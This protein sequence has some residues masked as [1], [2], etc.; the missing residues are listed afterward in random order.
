MHRN[1]SS[2]IAACLF[3]V[4][5]LQAPAAWAQQDED[6]I[7]LDPLIV[8][9]TRSA[10]RLSQTTRSVTVISAEDIAAQG[11]HT[12]A[13]ALRS[14]LGLDVVR[15][16]SLGATTSIFTRGSESDHTAVLID[17][18]KVNILLDGKFDMADLS[19][20]N[21]ER[22]EVVRGPA[23][24]LYGST[25]TGGVIHIITK[26]GSGPL[27]ANL[28]VS[29]GSFGTN[30]QRAI[31][32]GGTTWGGLSVS[33]SRVD[34]EGHLAF[35]NQYDNANVALRADLSPDERTNVDLTL[36]YIDSEYHFPTDGAGRVLFRNKYQTTHETTLGLRG[37]RAL[38]PWWNNSLQ[39]GFHQRRRHSYPESPEESLFVTSEKRLA[40]DW[41]SVLDFRL[42]ALTLGAA[43][44]DDEDTE[45]DFRR[46]TTAGYAQLRLKPVEPI[47]LVGGLRVDEHSKFGTELTYQV[48]AAYFLPGGTKLR[49][50]LG[51]GFKAP[52]LF[53]NLST[54]PGA[55]G[56]PNLDPERST[57]WELGVEHKLWA[58]R[59]RFEGT[60][61][62]SRFKDLIDWGPA[63]QG[64]PNYFNIQE[65]E[66]HGLELSA[67][68][69]PLPAWT[70]GAA[71]TWLR[72]EVTDAGFSTSATAAFVEGESLLRRP[73]HKVHAFGSY[74]QGR[75]NG[76][77]DLHHIGVRN[78]RH[79]PG[80]PQPTRAVDNPS[81]TKVNV[82]LGYKLIAGE[83][84]T[85]ELFG[86]VENL[87]DEDYYEVY[88]FATPGF[89]AFGGI[90]MTL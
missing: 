87:F 31:V 33:A 89:A 54:L 24:T 79:Y 34:S 77:L 58:D 86:R 68:V 57:T 9:A 73:E 27:S 4:L 19:V 36:R 74:A 59:L 11:A 16:G 38:L 75:F 80:W 56:N 85:L 90:R 35:N 65:A 78:D 72:S 70:F 18:V 46:Y 64:Q 32:S 55:L 53:E 88:G 30:T 6:A 69:T 60:F 40:I 17:G 7:R 48:S 3:V 52:T 84:R 13:D 2:L 21:I 66:A 14:V 51:S 10:E 71:Y 12:V 83:R 25:A 26:R 39:F 67:T 1:M 63:P 81:Y 5:G 49:A 15:A 44:E 28:N 61:F 76:R 62:S 43:H 42:G 47:V 22:I 41:Q 50:A 23:S 82:V 37:T 8:T 29:G 20:D 45:N